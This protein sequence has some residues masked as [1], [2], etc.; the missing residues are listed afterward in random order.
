MAKRYHDANPVKG[1]GRMPPV[2]RPTTAR[3][4]KSPNRFVITGTMREWVRTKVILPWTGPTITWD[5]VLDVVRKKYPGGKLQRQSLAKYEPLQRAFQATKRR[6]AEE[7]ASKPQDG[8][9]GSPTKAA[10]ARSGSEEYLDG[11]IKA[12]ETQLAKVTRENTELKSQFERWQLNAF[13]A[14]MTMQDLDRRRARADRGQ[15]DE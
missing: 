13:A 11:R 10:K 7:R 5:A 8:K 4:P 9:A 14:G 6:L 12:L 2:G 1:A 3:V 15:V